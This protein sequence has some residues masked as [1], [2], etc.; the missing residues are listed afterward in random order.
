MQKSPIKETIFCIRDLL[1]NRS[2]WPKPPH[3]Q[4]P[5]CW[6][7]LLLSF[8]FY[9]VSS[10]SPLLFLLLSLLQ[11]LSYIQRETFPLPRLFEIHPLSFRESLTLLERVSLSERESPFL[12]KERESEAEFL[13]RERLSLSLDSFRHPLSFLE[14]V[15]LFQRE[16]LS[17]RESLFEIPP[18]SSRESISLV[19]RV[20]LSLQRERKIGR[21]FLQ[22]DSLS[23]YRERLSLS[24]DSLRYPLSLSE[25]V[26]L[27]RERE[28]KK[29]R[30]SLQR[31][32]FSL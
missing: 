14:R 20:S 21:D 5:A 25:R 3:T 6:P 7:F 17:S 2:Y 16:F 23:L 18:L 26:S 4:L 31:E 8:S 28:G 27:S 30:V 1:F 15:S 19:E 29:G 9:C 24:L 12:Q 32:T 11:S 10:L 22:R 13:S